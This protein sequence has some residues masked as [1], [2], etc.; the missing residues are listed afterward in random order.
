M[1]EELFELIRT[2]QVCLWIGAGFSRY[3]G[4]PTGWGLKEKLEEGLP[5]EER[6]QLSAY[7]SLREFSEYYT[8]LKGGRQDLEGFLKHTF[9]QAPAS[10]YFHD[11]LSRVSHFKTIIT[12]NYDHLI[13][14]SYS[15]K[16]Y[17]VR[18]AKDLPGLNTD[19]CV[20]YKIHGDINDGGS[21]VITS[22]D[23]A[24][25]YNRGAKNPLWS[26]I[27]GEIAS[28]HMVFLGYGYEDDNIWADFDSV[29]GQ[30]PG[31]SLRRFM[32]G[33]GIDALKLARLK[34]EKI[35]FIQMSGE[36]FIIQLVEY[37]KQHVI[38]DM[39][40]G[41]VA[42]QVAL[43]FM[44][45]FG[46]VATTEM[47]EYKTRLL[48]LG[49]R[50]GKTDS[51]IEFRTDDKDFIAEYKKLVDG[52]G[53]TVVEIPQ[54]KLLSFV[55]SVEGFHWNTLE[56]ISRFGLAMLPVLSEACNVEFPDHD[57][58]L[59]GLP[60]ELF[61]FH[62]KN[63]RLKTKVHGFDFELNSSIT[64]SKKTDVKIHMAA[65]AEFSS[66]KAYRDAY[67]VFDLLLSGEE[68]RLYRPGKP[69]PLKQKLV[70][71]GRVQEIR[72][73]REIYS[74]LATI[75]NYFDVRFSD[76]QPGSIT[77]EDRLNINM[78]TSL[79]NKKYHA[80]EIPEGIVFQASPDTINKLKVKLEPDMFFVLHAQE[81]YLELFGQR[82]DLGEEQIILQKPTDYHLD[83]KTHTLSVRDASNLVVFKYSRL[84]FEDFSTLETVFE[85][86]IG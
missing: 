49:K 46:M 42:P 10:T 50:N 19:Q 32:V 35:E 5:E 2:Q 86:K 21:M 11:L 28:K 77:E 73:F 48:S 65:P 81:K 20:I 29:Y 54:D 62:N 64:K 47:D 23:Y 41:R 82:L 38:A 61:V 79:I 74:A 67:I 75:E 40:K 6:A 22:K 58:E 45:G 3:A 51:K 17:V 60:I 59:R 15:R 24:Q 55:H 9:S 31:H 78:L 85:K 34:R 56:E 36:D 13:E 72:Y 52:T 84:G 14:D 63:L 68:V 4:Y 27:N 30:L 37:L 18:S 44:S 7:Q 25:M 8:V 80:V 39:E 53:S 12:T 26:R 70:L 43:N 83:P 33:P 66:V 16:A 57:V 1:L 69:E 71:P 76:V